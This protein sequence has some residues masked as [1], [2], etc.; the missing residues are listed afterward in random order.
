MELPHSSLKLLTH[1]QSNAQTVCQP[2]DRHQLSAPVSYKPDHRNPALWFLADTGPSKTLV[3][4]CSPW[5]D[6]WMAACDG[7]AAQAATEP[8]RHPTCGTSQDLASGHSHGR[9]EGNKCWQCRCLLS[10]R[11]LLSLGASS[12][13]DLSSPPYIGGQE[14]V[15]EPGLLR[16]TA[17]GWLRRG[18]RGNRR[19]LFTELRGGAWTLVPWGAKKDC[20][21]W[22]I[23]PKGLG[24]RW[25]MGWRG[26]R[27][28]S[29]CNIYAV[30][31]EVTMKAGVSSLTWSLA[32]WTYISVH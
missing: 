2:P 14:G 11:I 7:R 10:I 6:M 24:S 30:T 19:R 16:G 22:W 15:L 13:L 17:W 25:R 3:W 4:S 1:A 32:I 28:L 9:S 12:C 23:D 26:W 8:L 21:C 20:C 29:E 31:T 18:E 27:V 5:M